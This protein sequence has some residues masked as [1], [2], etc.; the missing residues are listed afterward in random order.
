MVW[1]PVG[2]NSTVIGW[3]ITTSPLKKREKKH[4]HACYYP[5]PRRGHTGRQLRA[6]IPAMLP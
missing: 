1:L 3:G 6:A 2:F 5:A 4:Q